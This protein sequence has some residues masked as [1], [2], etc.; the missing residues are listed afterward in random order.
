V[1]IAAAGIIYRHEYEAVDEALVWHTIQRDLAALR[2]V[3]EEE[4]LRLP[5][6]LISNG[7]TTDG[8]L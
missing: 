3:A 8:L 6:H 2:S 1:A 5:L 4:L 7:R